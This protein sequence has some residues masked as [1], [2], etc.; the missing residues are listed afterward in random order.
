M[1]NVSIDEYESV[2]EMLKA[3]KELP[4]CP[5]IPKPRNSFDVQKGIEISMNDAGVTSARSHFP[6][7]GTYGL[8]GC[9]GIMAYNR[10]TMEGG[11]A[12]LSMVDTSTDVSPHGAEQLHRMLNRL[13]GHPDDPIEIRM[14]SGGYH[15][16]FTQNVLAELQKHKNI[17]ITG[18]GIAGECFGLAVAVDTRRWDKGIYVGGH[19]ALPPPEVAPDDIEPKLWASI[20]S[21]PYKMS[22]NDLRR[23]TSPPGGVV[24]GLALGRLTTADLRASLSHITPSL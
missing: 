11:V 17:H 22:I 2:G 8:Q 24:D 9:M 21:A 4:P 16:K 3:V 20:H 14:A 6:I 18:M 13:Q 1:S 15:D 19:L 5:L 10:R 7:I 12:H 23:E